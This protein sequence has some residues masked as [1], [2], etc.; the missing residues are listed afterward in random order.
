MAWPRAH[1]SRESRRE[2]CRLMGRNCLHV[3]SRAAFGHGQSFVDQYGERL[4]GGG[5]GY[6]VLAPSGRSRPEAGPRLGVHRTGSI[7]KSVG[8]APIDRGFVE[9]PGDCCTF[10][11]PLSPTGFGVSR[12]LAPSCPRSHRYRG[13]S[14]ASFGRIVPVWRSPGV[15]AGPLP[16]NGPSR[17]SRGPPSARDDR[18]QYGAR[19]IDQHIV[20]GADPAEAAAVLEEL[21]GERGGGR[22]ARDPGE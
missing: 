6:A 13:W 18:G 11:H 22:H 1:C 10:D 21:D 4:P 16:W 12:E 20:D 14:R 2:P 7:A 3:D 9:V 8:D 15:L 5:T 17:Y 19:R